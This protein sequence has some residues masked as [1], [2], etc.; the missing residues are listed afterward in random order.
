M[1]ATATEPSRMRVEIEIGAGIDG[2]ILEI[3]HGRS[4]EF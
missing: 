4:M 1:C 3:N 2:R